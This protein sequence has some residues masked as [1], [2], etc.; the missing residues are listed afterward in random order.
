MSI[1]LTTRGDRFIPSRSVQNQTRA[2]ARYS[3][4]PAT[5]TLQRVFRDAMFP[6][7]D[8]VLCLSGQAHKRPQTLHPAR[9]TF[10]FERALDLPGLSHEFTPHGVH[11]GNADLLAIFL[12]DT[13]YVQNLRGEPNAKSLP[14]EN[15][16]PT[17]VRW[18]PST[19][20]LLAVGSASG[21][22]YKWEMGSAASTCKSLLTPK[23]GS[24]QKKVSCLHWLNEN[25][26]FF[27]KGK[28]LKG[29][30]L[31]QP[32]GQR[33]RVCA[34]SAPNNPLVRLTGS[35]DGTRIASGSK[36]GC[37]KIYD[38]RQW[39]SALISIEAASGAP[40]QA[41]QYH[42]IHR[43]LA[44][45]THT[46]NSPLCIHK[47]CD[48]GV[49]RVS[50]SHQI[51]DLTWLD[52]QTLATAHGGGPTSTKLIVWHY[53][54]TLTDRPF[55]PLT[56]LERMAARPEDPSWLEDTE[57][58][59][60]AKAPD[61]SRDF[62]SVDSFESLCIWKDSEPTK[63]PKLARPISRFLTGPEMR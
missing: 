53:C 21:A 4:Q 58:L 31:R 17:A 11:W 51:R 38:V 14:M 56:A 44:Y 27:T 20:P 8:D 5:N 16:P 13:V 37:V 25:E 24:Q 54:S 29:Y 34:T 15:N 41:L 36:N 57:I 49:R 33:T 52:H 32:S 61:T 12:N 43:V 26:L 55:E 50:T 1:N 62:L 18:S 46:A 22:I 6:H 47:E 30:D 60:L 40:V 10:V 48:N 59:A 2:V 23:E 35:S 7:T 39:D 3:L 9:A 45:G 63:K 42:P 28:H 19:Q